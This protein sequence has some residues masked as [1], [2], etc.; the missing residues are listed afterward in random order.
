M[1][2]RVGQ[3]LHSRAEQKQDEGKAR[4]AQHSREPE[5]STFAPFDFLEPSLVA[6]EMLFETLVF[7]RFELIASHKPAFADALAE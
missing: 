6:R 4:Q 7:V 2:R 1:F 3:P 5:R